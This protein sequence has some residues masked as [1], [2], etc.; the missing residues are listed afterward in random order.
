MTCQLI[1]GRRN[2]DRTAALY[3]CLFNGLDSGKRV[4]LIL[5]EQAT[6]L[7]ERQIEEKR[8][9]RSL[10]NLEITSFRRLA[11]RYVLSPSLDALGRSLLIYGILAERRDDFLA[12]KPK[13]ISVGFVEDIGAVLKEVSMNGLSAEFLR[14]QAA[15]FENEE[16]AG[17][18]GAKLRDIA[19]LREAMDERG[20]SDE[21]GRLFLFADRV[22]EEKLFGDALFCFDDFYDFTAAEYEVIRALAEQ[23]ASFSFAFLC[24]RNEAVFAKTGRAASRLIA[25]AGEY[26]LPLELTALKA[27]S[28]ETETALSFLERRFF[29]Y[30]GSVFRGDTDEIAI[31]AAENR[32]AEIRFMAR[33]ICDL[34]DQGHSF[35]DIGVCFRDISGYDRQIEEI[36]ASYGIPCYVDHPVS[37][38]HHPVYRFAVGLLRLAAE[39]WSYASY[40]ALLKTGLFPV[41]EAE[42]DLLENYCLA[43]AIKGRRFYQDAPW[44]YR[45]ERENEDPEAADAIRRRVLEILLPLTERIQKKDTVNAYAAVIWDFLEACRVDQVVND[46]REQEEER[47]NLRKSA[48]LSAGITAFAEMLDQVAAAFPDREFTLSEYMELLRMGAA[49]VT[50]RT[51]PAELNTVEISVLGISRPARRDFVFLG[52]VNE[53]VFPSGVS[54][55]GFLNI[56]DRALLREKTES[57]IQDKDFYYESEDILVYQALTMAKKKLFVSCA[58]RGDEGRAYPSPLISFLK[59]MFPAVRETTLRDDIG[60][61]GL[62]GSLEEVFAALPLSLRENTV[63]GWDRIK[64]RLLAEKTTA[65]R[66]E[67]LLTSLTYT[68]QSGPLSEALLE[69][70]PG[71]DLSLSVSSI[72]L[73]RRCP[74]SYF[75]RYGLKLR[76]RKLLR[77]EAPDLGNIY[78]DTLRELMETLN[79]EK[80]AWPSLSAEKERIDGLVDNMVAEKLRRLSE[81]NLFP[82]EHLVF[83]SHVLAEN[84]KFVIE[85]MT[86][87]AEAGDLFIPALWEVPFGDRERLPA[88]VIPVDGDGRLIRLRGVIDRVDVAEKDGEV[89]ERVVDYKSSDKALSMEDI[90]YGVMPQL[91]IYMMVMEQQGKGKPAGIFYQSMKDAMVREEGVLSEEELRKK[92][93]DEMAMKGYIIG[94]GVGETCFGAA[95]KAKVLSVKQYEWVRDHTRRLIT[96][97]GREI[98]GGR[99]EIH[100]YLRKKTRSCGFC[101]YSAVCGYEPEVMGKEERLPDLKESEAMFRMEKE[102]DEA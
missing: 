15:L 43:H 45:D 16:T 75:A 3:D 41:A 40:F 39:K 64:E 74:F 82:E 26:G 88:Y 83:I 58:L 48:E 31:T 77:F 76:E 34:L 80:I 93:D 44:T 91:L 57:W 28:E 66:T 38:L 1:T 90:Y 10:W 50:V 68:G 63:A 69:E 101:P 30:D 33:T 6:F 67:R 60:G 81:E 102:G 18:L 47:G 13:D 99:T 52:G 62:F 11:E 96:R 17:D 89:Y 9:G 56:T 98:F 5:P 49:A 86:R 4:F 53:G 72:E 51:I 95:E 78:H 92:L 94:D 85:T 70:Y 25:I 84:L 79:A 54:D 21:N 29:R 24:D 2:T 22:R 20:L 87:Q 14:E 37:L 59:K 42:C 27:P 7:H 35:D 97:I 36:F 73:F 23:G 32:R 19:L 71:R 12:L 8:N 46:W 65:A 100:P 55:G 61:D